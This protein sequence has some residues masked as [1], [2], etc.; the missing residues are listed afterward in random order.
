MGK[1]ENGKIFRDDEPSSNHE[2]PLWV[3]W[4]TIG[5]SLLTLKTKLKKELK[6]TL[7]PLMFYGSI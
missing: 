3:N 1:W 5:K 2:K 7:K 6:L 4:N